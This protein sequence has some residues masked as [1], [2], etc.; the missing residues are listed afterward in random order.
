MEE[1][2]LP[3]PPKPEQEHANSHAFTGR[4]DA[5]CPVCHLTMLGEPIVHT[6]RDRYTHER[7]L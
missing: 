2:L 1:G 3:P 7:C 4:Y 5:D 6:S